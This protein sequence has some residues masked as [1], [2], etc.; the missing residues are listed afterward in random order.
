MDKIIFC[1]GKSLSGFLEELRRYYNSLDFSLG[2]C[3]F[4]Q[5]VEISHDDKNDQ[6]R[7]AEHQVMNR[8]ILP[9]LPHD[10]YKVAQLAERKELELEQLEEVALE[11]EDK[12]QGRDYDS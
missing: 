4:Y 6:Q 12:R 9:E 2:M 3:S 11:Y 10:I 8:K 5:E 7:A 1:S